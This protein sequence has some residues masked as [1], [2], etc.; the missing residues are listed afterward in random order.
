MY[1]KNALCALT[2]TRIHKGDTVYGFNILRQYERERFFPCPAYIKGTYDGYGDIDCNEFKHVE[3]MNYLFTSKFNDINITSSRFIDTEYCKTS[4]SYRFNGNE[5]IAG[6]CFIHADVFDNMAEKTALSYGYSLDNISLDLDTLIDEIISTKNKTLRM[7]R[8]NS[9]FLEND[10]DND[11]QDFENLSLILSEASSD[12]RF[13]NIKPF[14]RNLLSHGEKEEAKHTTLCLIKLY[15]V[16]QVFKQTKR[17]W[18]KNNSLLA[19]KDTSNDI[20]VALFEE[21]L[22]KVK[23]S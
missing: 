5:N 19:G 21:C 11:K 12:I 3:A 9:F 16:N 4:L 22:K 7:K 23:K 14:I 6:S 1:Y 15:F 17:T 8:I 20:D 13:S 10:E 2:N 18:D